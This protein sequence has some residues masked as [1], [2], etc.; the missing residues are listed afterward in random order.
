MHIKY[1][2]FISLCKY[3]LVSFSHSF[4][5]FLSSKDY[6]IK[7]VDSIKISKLVSATC[8]NYMLRSWPNFMSSVYPLISSFALNSGKNA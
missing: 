7:Q 8:K 4:E 2:Y 3:I 1:I 5:S 6:T